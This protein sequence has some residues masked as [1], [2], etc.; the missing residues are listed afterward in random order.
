MHD[1][2]EVI[3]DLQKGLSLKFVGDDSRSLESEF[4]T[5]LKAKKLRGITA[6]L[7]VTNKRIIVTPRAQRRHTVDT[8]VFLGY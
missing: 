5:A 6:D 3:Q 2:Q 4:S 1:E 8:A 7:W